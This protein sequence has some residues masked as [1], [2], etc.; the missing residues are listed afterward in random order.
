VDTLQFLC[1]F[2]STPSELDIFTF[3]VSRSLRCHFALSFTGLPYSTFIFCVKDIFASQSI[4]LDR[5]LPKPPHEPTFAMSKNPTPSILPT[6]SLQIPFHLL[7]THS[8]PSNVYSYAVRH[9]AP[10]Y[11]LRG[12][13]K[14]VCPEIP[15]SI[16][17]PDARPV[18]STTTSESKVELED[19]VAI[20][21]ANTLKEWDRVIK[22]GWVIR[23]AGGRDFAEG[24][25]LVTWKEGDVELTQYERK[26][27]GDELWSFPAVLQRF[28]VEIGRTGRETI[29]HE[30][31]RLEAAISDYFSVE[32]TTEWAKVMRVMYSERCWMKV[33]VQPSTEDAAKSPQ[34]AIDNEF[35]REEELTSTPGWSMDTVAKML[36]LLVGFERELLSLTTLSTI[37]EFWPLS[38]FLE[39]LAVK[40]LR[41][42]KK[43]MWHTLRVGE[44]KR[45]KQKR[46]RVWKSSLEHADG[47][48]KAFEDDLPGLWTVIDKMIG[49][50]R[51]QRGLTGLLQEISKFEEKG[52][53]TPVTF[54]HPTRDQEEKQ[55]TA[56]PAITSI[57]FQGHHSTL[58]AE[59]L[60]A[61]IDFVACLIEYARS[62][63]YASL[64]LK[65]HSFR[66]TAE[67]IDEEVEKS[68]ERLLDILDVKPYTKKVFVTDVRNKKAQKEKER[69]Q[70]N[71]LEDSEEEDTKITHAMKEHDLFTPLKTLILKT[72]EKEIEYMPIFIKRYTE[73]GGFFAMPQTKVH[74]LLL[75]SSKSNHKINDNRG[76]EGHTASWVD[77]L[78]DIENGEEYEV[79]PSGLIV[80]SPIS[81]ASASRAISPVSRASAASPQHLTPISPLRSPKLITLIGESV[82][83]IDEVLNPSPRP[84]DG[85]GDNMGETKISNLVERFKSGPRLG[86]REWE[87]K[88]EE[89]RRRAV[90]SP[91]RKY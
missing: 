74:D 50:G 82:G 5:V 68:L 87:R 33:V 86:N 69:E 4:A 45:A 14:N 42:E 17:N 55:Q 31:R 65:V 70:L 19:R 71:K 39:Y 85:E 15:V 49:G 88:Y 64:R 34:L 2:R 59:E 76:R 27:L 60:L 79:G 77:D 72:Q 6:F 37:L 7:G 91:T 80:A 73:A 28:G 10:L 81:P 66:E 9:T 56:H 38:R 62:R 51:G 16:W 84:G 3:L 44:S 40:N 1:L 8:I 61:Y 67:D 21:E 90:S 48:E 63:S 24:M 20:W 83:R 29:E 13:F 78:Q 52:G 23:R 30:V 43:K 53:R 11:I 32:G 57:V 22:K 89:R 58:N 35:P 54:E 75:A 36:L 18:L 47:E 46:K 12:A 41:N 26:L 25:G